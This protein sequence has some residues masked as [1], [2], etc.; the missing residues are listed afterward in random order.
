M[1]QI[2][3]LFAYGYTHRPNNQAG[4]PVTTSRLF[5]HSS[6]KSTFISDG[7]RNGIIACHHSWCVSRSIIAAVCSPGD[8]GG[9]LGGSGQAGRFPLDD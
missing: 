2:K 6:G 8:G 4:R 9:G 1:L 3:G 5:S 7:L